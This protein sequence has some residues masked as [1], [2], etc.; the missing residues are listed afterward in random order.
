MKRNAQLL[1][2]CGILFV[3]MITVSCG[4]KEKD[5]DENGPETDKRVQGE[6]DQ[7]ESGATFDDAKGLQ[8]KEET[9]QALGLKVSPVTTTSVKGSLLLHAQV[10]RAATEPVFAHTREQA[11]AAYATALMKPEDAA[12]LT[13]GQ[14]SSSLPEAYVWRIDATLQE[15]TGQVEALLRLP[16]FQAE[17]G[18]VVDVTFD[19]PGPAKNVLCV[20]PSALLRGS[21][22]T[23]IYVQKG[24][25]LQ[26]VTVEIGSQTATYVEITKGLEL[27]DVVVTQPVQEIYLIELRLTKGGGE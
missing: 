5:T 15:T 27:R 3:A 18:S 23:F 25:Y 24:D 22:G 17:V 1:I 19:E 2:R 7:S 6:A 9:K 20:P 21:T 11:G 8:L 16:N 4:P 10:Y 26:R 13:S 14:K 12:K